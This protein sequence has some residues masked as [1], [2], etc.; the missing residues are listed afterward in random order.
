MDSND[1][2]FVESEVKEW[3]EAVLALK[4]K[5]DFMYEICRIRHS[6]FG[7]KVIFKLF[8]SYMFLNYRKH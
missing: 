5:L 7:C 6:I 1:I 2:N 8:T 3:T 4:A